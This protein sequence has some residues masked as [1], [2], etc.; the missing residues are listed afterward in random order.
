[1]DVYDAA[2]WM[3]ITALSEISIKEGG[4]PQKLPDF[5]RGRWKTRTRLDVTDFPIV[6]REIKGK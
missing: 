1:M 6:V 5:T 3:C 4:A 2:S